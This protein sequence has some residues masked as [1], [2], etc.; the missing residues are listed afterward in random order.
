MFLK[1]YHRFT[2]RGAAW[3]NTQ[4]TVSFTAFGLCPHHQCLRLTI[5]G[6]YSQAKRDREEKHCGQ[7]ENDSDTQDDHDFRTFKRVSSQ[8]SLIFEQLSYL[9]NDFSSRLSLGNVCK[10]Y[11]LTLQSSAA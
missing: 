10:R 4:Q 1:L 6:I 11:Q 9:R 5:L 3:A 7:A 2:Q 8:D